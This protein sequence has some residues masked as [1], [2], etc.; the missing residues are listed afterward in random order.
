MTHLIL[1]GIFVLMSVAVAALFAVRTFRQAG[2]QHKIYLMIGLAALLSAAIILIDIFTPRKRLSALSGV[3]LGLIVGMIGAYAFSFLVDYVQ[4]FVRRMQEADGP[5]RSY[6]TLFLG[7][8]VFI[9]VVCVFVAT[10]VI[11]QTKD[12]F[13]F[14]IPYV[15]F[16]KQIRGPRPMVLDTSAIVDGRILDIANTQILAGLIVAPRFVLDEMQTIADSSDKLKRARGR[17]GLDILTKLQ[18]HPLL[19]VSIEDADVEG[20]TVDQ[21]LVSLCQDLHARLITTDFN[22]TK[23]AK[24]RNVEVININTLAEAL[25]PVVLPGESMSVCLIKPGENADQGVG[26]L[27]DGTMVVVEQGRDRVGQTVNLTVTSML[28]TS[29]GRMIFGK[30]AEGGP[31]SQAGVVDDRQ[32]TGAGGRQASSDT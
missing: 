14:V 28:Q 13:R 27:E 4:F 18:E 25:R 2:D 31:R 8:K 7:L 1:R 30:I 6:E 5:S 32:T 16:A 23:I 26:Y 15:E 12:D 29:A 10:S 22:L 19:D 24:V 3:V 11:L 9:G 17:R 21:K 20:A